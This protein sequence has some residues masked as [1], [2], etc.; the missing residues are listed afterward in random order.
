MMEA[1]IRRGSEGVGRFVAVDDLLVYAAL[2]S[3]PT[4]IQRVGYNLARSL[5]DDCGYQM[6]RVSG[7]SV[8]E[9]A[10]RRPATA[11]WFTRAT[12]FVLSSLS[13]LPASI[14][15]RLRALGPSVMRRLRP[16]RSGATVIFNRGDWVVVL[17]APWIAEGM[18]ESLLR[19]RRSHGVRI[20]LLV[21]DL[22]PITAQ[23]WF[24]G[25]VAVE[26]QSQV[27]TLI[28]NADQLLTVSQEVADEI[29]RIFGRGAT[30]INPADPLVSDNISPQ[31]SG[32]DT[33]PFVLTVGTMHPRKNLAAL[34]RIWDLWIREC[35][36]D[37]NDAQHVPALLIVGRRHPEDQD[38]HNELAKSPRAASKIRL[39]HSMSDDALAGLYAGCRFVIMPSHAEGWGLP[40]REAFVYGKPVIATDGIPAAAGMPGALVVR[41]GDESALYQAARA[42]WESDEP[43][44][45]SA[46]IQRTFVQRKWHDVA[47]ELERSVS[48]YGR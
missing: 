48:T 13:H 17:G 47:V 29:M 6:V 35:E 7:S 31:Q 34:V 15:Q 27:G 9:A 2:L 10:L 33:E 21:H 36:A 26:A 28:D 42:W 3:R 30:V 8:Q 1:Q 5:V 18:T 46:Q 19:L 32:P 23:Q 45:R 20:C 39:L 22:L 14:Q 24:S 43:E 12:E 41:A 44:K 38:L 25:R 16:P 37:G 4:G 40:V 11:S